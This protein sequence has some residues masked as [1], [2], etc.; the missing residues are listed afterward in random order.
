M[1]N[2]RRTRRQKNISRVLREKKPQR[3]IAILKKKVGVGS[4]PTQIYNKK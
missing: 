4:K 3:K 2:E 1:S